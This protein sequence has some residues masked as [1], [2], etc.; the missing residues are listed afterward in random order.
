[1]KRGK[2]SN[3]VSRSRE[4]RPGLGRAG[5]VPPSRVGKKGMVIYADPALVRRLKILAVRQDSTLQA[6]GLQ[7]I[8]EFLERYE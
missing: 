6:L 8:E 7:A 4:S 3:A 5:W 2:L 1:M